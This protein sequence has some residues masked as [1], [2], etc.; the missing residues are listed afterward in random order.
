[1][2]TL[3]HTLFAAFLTF[4]STGSAL[5]DDKFSQTT[6][7]DP[8]QARELIERLYRLEQAFLQCS[9]VMMTGRELKQLDTAI[10]EVE[11]TSGIAGSDLESIYEQ[12]ENAASAPETFCA[13]MT[14]AAM[15]VQAIP[16]MQQ[17]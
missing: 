17:R 6:V 13:G 8:E 12:V 14:S 16:V 7:R 9:N 4:A 1:M 15:E 3:K 11:L 2:S 10:L 5:S